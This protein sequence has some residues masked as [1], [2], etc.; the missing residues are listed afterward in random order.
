MSARRY[1]S[2]NGL[3]G[4]VQQHHARSNGALVGVYQGDQA[5]LDTDNGTHPWSTVC[6]AHGTVICHRTLVLAK[7]HAV[8]PEG[9]CDECT[10]P[11]KA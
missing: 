11:R 6:E 10:P 3:A 4:C 1:Y 7:F 5:G 8:D 9:W 2:C